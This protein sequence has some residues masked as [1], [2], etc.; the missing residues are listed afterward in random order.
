MKKASKIILPIILLIFTLIISSC[1]N[2]IP[3]VTEPE[4]PSEAVTNEETTSPPPITTDE[5]TTEEIT[6]EEIT[7]EEVTTEEITTEEVTTEEVTTAEVTTE[8]VSAEE[9]TTEEV[10][11]EEITTEAPHGHLWGSWKVVKASTCENM[12]LE[13]RS[14][15]CGETQ[16]RDTRALGH[17]DGKWTVS[18]EATCTADGIRVLNCLRCAKLLQSENIPMKGHVFGAWRVLGSASCTEKGFE[19]RSCSCGET[20]SRE[21]APRGHRNEQWVT[22]SR[23]SCTSDGVKEKKCGACGEILDREITSAFGHSEGWTVTEQALS[24]TSDGIKHKVCSRCTAILHTEIT[25]S[26][27]H[28]AGE[29]FTNDEKSTAEIG[30]RQKKCLYC[31]LV[32]DEVSQKSLALIE[33]ERVSAAIN[34]VRGENSFTFAAMSDIHVDNVGTGYNQLPTKKSCEF[35]VRTLSLMEKL[36]MID[37]AAMLGDYTASGHSY[38]IDHIKADFEYVRDTFGDLGDFPVAWIRGNHEINYYADAERPTTNDE[39]YEYIDSNSRGL[40][41]DPANPKGGY[42]YIDF[43]DNKIRMI[44]L[45]TSDVYTEYSF[46]KGEDA[47]A[48]GVSSAQLRW[49]AGTAL[50]FSDKANAAKWGIII[51]SHAPLDYTKDITRLLLILEAYREGGSGSIEYTLEGS[52]YS[53]RYDFGYSAR[54]EIIC[55]IHGHIHNF[56]QDIISSSDSVEPWLPRLCAPNMC[57]GRENTPIGSLPAY[58]E[59]W[60]DFDKNGEP[61]FYT[62]CHWDAEK[63]TYIYDEESGTSYCMITVNRDT[64]TIYAH[65]VGNGYDRTIKY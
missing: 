28:V 3:E 51:N 34:A 45:N 39:L 53:I 21:L 19:T 46:V 60:G 36:T 55:S 44:F 47:P 38:S 13:S 17:V 5:V 49:L 30:V 57:A 20:Q 54:A 22:L 15:D 42:G 18:A 37:A 14:C 43:P 61:L 50:D 48:L 4:T 64:R 16:I 35:A 33:A 31:D 9:F 52:F 12:G 23:A 11:T 10:T 7:F 62:K 40:T 25:E 63:G 26:P 1:N 29:W 6:T 24:C 8:E 56:K 2:G 41:V 58:E 27:G 65:Y 32:M 59:K